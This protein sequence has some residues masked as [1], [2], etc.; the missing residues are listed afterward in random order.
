M[1]RIE[2][3]ITR[4]PFSICAVIF[5]ASLYRGISTPTPSGAVGTLL[6]VGTSALVLESLLR[7]EIKRGL[8]AKMSL[9]II[10]ECLSYAVFSFFLPNLAYRQGT[11][12]VFL[13][14][15]LLPVFL[16]MLKIRR[17]KI[18]EMLFLTACFLAVGISL[19]AVWF[20]FGNFSPDSYS[21]YEIAETIG[22]DF[23]RTGT[24]RQYVYVS[25]Y[26]CSFPYMY[27][28]LLFLV[29][30]ITGLGIYSGCLLNL[31]LVG[32]TIHILIKISYEFSGKYW[33]G[34][35]SMVLL[36][37][38]SFY[39]E[40]VT[41]AKSIPAAL[42]CMLWILYLCMKMWLTEDKK[43]LRLVAVGLLSG[44]L[45]VLRFDGLAWFFFGLIVMLLIN[46]GCRVRSA[47]VYL[48]CGFVFLAP[49]AVYSFLHFGKI[50]CSDNNGT[51]F[52]VHAISPNRVTLET[53]PLKT[54]FN[55]PLTWVRALLAKC[56]RV[57]TSLLECSFGCDLF[58]A[59]GLLENVRDL[60]F[61][62][63]NWKRQKKLIQL[64]G[65]FFV[66]YAAK[67]AMY[68]LV[69]YGA[70]RYHVETVTII[71]LLL[72]MILSRQYDDVLWKKLNA[73]KGMLLIIIICTALIYSK[74]TIKNFFTGF[75][76]FPLQKVTVIPEEVRILEEDLERLKIPEQADIMLMGD[77]SAFGGW[78]KRH[79]LVLPVNLSVD[80]FQ[81]VIDTWGQD[82]VYVTVKKEDDE[83]TR[84]EQIQEIV[85]YLDDSEV[86]KIS[87]ENYEIYEVTKE[88][89][90]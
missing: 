27:P 60:D 58:L 14:L 3:I 71:T 78:S 40:E 75:L 1:R 31:I 86:E 63:Q 39:L 61:A 52:L 82:A 47:L 8:S 73:A 83:Y 4:W 80:T 50:W 74:G 38:N 15:L 12:S 37:V 66:Y 90:E 72:M 88:V 43:T 41:A 89:N 81:Y 33:P 22:K 11:V 29:D 21:Y 28:L 84:S 48:V 57:L 54:L 30:S 36:L 49:W 24:I 25:E 85:D 77:G 6:F 68:V 64:F 46:K 17:G 35:L 62:K 56:F 53:E 55:S 9:L 70:T 10:A 42:L 76:A 16:E 65:I 59:V 19:Y 32:F 2:T 18:H 69:G 67:T 87:A 26:N 13:F 44:L 51:L 5:G 34:M 79:V 23:G 7:K 45:P 20:F